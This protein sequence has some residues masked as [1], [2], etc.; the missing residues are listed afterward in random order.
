[1][2]GFFGDD[3]QQPDRQKH[4]PLIFMMLL[5]RLPR[6][7]L[8]PTCLA[9]PDPKS[10]VSTIPPPGQANH[11]TERDDFGTGRRKVLSKS[12]L[13]SMVKCQ[14]GEYHV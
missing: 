5:K 8:E 11:Y 9:A 2:S 4:K 3:H 1:M 6:I 14:N 7:G 10:G 13:Y 12:T